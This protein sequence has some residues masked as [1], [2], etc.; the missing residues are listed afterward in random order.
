M[1][2]KEVLFGEKYSDAWSLLELEP[3][4]AKKKKGEDF[5]DAL[6]AAKGLKYSTREVERIRKKLRESSPK[7]SLHFLKSIGVP[8]DRLC[9]SHSQQTDYRSVGVPSRLS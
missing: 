4:H 3:P 1:K 5:R 2:S 6:N 9:R 8:S 7:E